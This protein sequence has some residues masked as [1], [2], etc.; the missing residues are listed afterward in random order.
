MN[1]S[2]TWHIVGAGAMG[3][4]L[5]HR[6]QDS[7]LPSQLLCRGQGTRSIDLVDADQR[8]TYLAKGIESIAPRHIDALVLATKAGDLA[9]AL[10]QVRS[11]LAF[12]AQVLVLANGL[13]FEKQLLAEC[14]NA[15]FY[16][17]I[18]T[19]GAFTDKTGTI[20]VASRGQTSVG[21]LRPVVA[22]LSRNAT[23]P[24]Q[25]PPIKSAPPWYE[26]NFGML[27][28]WQW[29][30]SIDRTAAKKFMINCIINPLTVIENCQNGAL[31][32]GPRGAIL[33]RLCEETEPFART[34]GLW[35]TQQTLISAVT[36]ICERTASNRSSMLQDVSAGRPTEIR[37]LTAQLLD[38]A[39]N[40]DVDLPLNR[41]VFDRVR[42]LEKQSVA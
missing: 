4:L 10:S 20:I 13:G 37:F 26:K 28:E 42:T 3:T 30:L 8:V 23:T 5:H 39:S 11:K 32:L 22:Q 36:S 40:W 38:L 25:T 41:Q 33:R 31:V 27:D 16:R 24:T 2:V 6:L 17:A 19:A 18:S 7:G 29:D 21:A 12:G 35:D 34:V 15:S 9:G 14:E 1:T